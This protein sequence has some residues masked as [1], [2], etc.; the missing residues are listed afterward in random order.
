MRLNSGIKWSL[1]GL[2]TS[3]LKQMEQLQKFKKSQWKAN[4]QILP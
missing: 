1:R 4:T 3:S 2:T